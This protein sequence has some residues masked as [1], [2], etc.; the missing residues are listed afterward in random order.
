[1]TPCGTF[2]FAGSEDGYVYAWNTDTG[3]LFICRHSNIESESG[4]EK[5]VQYFFVSYMFLLKIPMILA[6]RI[7]SIIKLLPECIQLS[8]TKIKMEK[9]SICCIW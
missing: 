8:F 7:L 5:E 4:Q 1:M 3:K 9:P 2:V 6:F